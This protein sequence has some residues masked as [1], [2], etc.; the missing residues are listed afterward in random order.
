MSQPTCI[1]CAYY[2]PNAELHAPEHGWQTCLTGQRRLE[3][4]LLSIRAAYLRLVEDIAVEAGARD[5]V[6]QALPGALT[7]SPSNQPRVAGTRERQLPINADRIDL[8]LPVVP[9]YVRDPHRDQ[10]GNLS[11]A[12]VLNEWVA[13]WHDRWCYHERYPTTNAINLI[14]WILAPTRLLRICQSGEALGDLAE[15]LRTLRSRLRY[16]LGESEKKPAIMWGVTCP[17][18]KL[19]SQLRLDLDD[20]DY[21]RECTNCGLLLS[22]EDY[23]QHLR[24]LVD[25]HRAPREVAPGSDV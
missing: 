19:V 10:V 18:C 16:A 25:A 22:R 3:H 5:G 20:P 2:R 24:G 7:P 13:E 1:L 6:S 14:D 12:T 11:I 17:R 23:L 8:L 4:E 15:E 9:G 21:Y